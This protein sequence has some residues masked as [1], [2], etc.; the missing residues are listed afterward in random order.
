M[1]DNCHKSEEEATKRSEEIF[2]EHFGTNEYQMMRPKFF[3]SALAENGAL[4]VSQ[5]VIVNNIDETGISEETKVASMI[6]SP[7]MQD[8]LLYM[9]AIA[10]A[11]RAVEN[12]EG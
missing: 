4:I 8:D 1:C 3:A 2:N 11:R 5:E 6:F 9:L 7:E 12:G 10:A